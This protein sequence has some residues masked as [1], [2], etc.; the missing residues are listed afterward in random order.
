ML[1][2]TINTWHCQDNLRHHA[3]V[4]GQH[5]VHRQRKPVQRQGKQNLRHT[6][7]PKAIHQPKVP[8]TAV[9]T[10]LAEAHSEVSTALGGAMDAT[11]PPAI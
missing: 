8:Y 3:L 4:D 6:P 2:G 5:S 7:M 11:S 10:P 1:D 9:L